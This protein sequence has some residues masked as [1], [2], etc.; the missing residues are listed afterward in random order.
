VT[1]NLGS[2]L[3]ELE[4][5]ARKRPVGHLLREREPTEE[6]PEVVGQNEQGEAYPVGGEPRAGESR[7]GEGVLAFPDVLLARASV[8]VEMDDGFR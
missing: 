1:D 2:N 7:P 3:Y 5:D 4:L 8:V 6:V